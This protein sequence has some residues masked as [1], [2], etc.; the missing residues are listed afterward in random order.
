[1]SSP[2]L[3]KT[4]ERQLMS[5]LSRP[6]SLSLS[7]SLALSVWGLSFTLSANVISYAKSITCLE[8][9][10][11]AVIYVTGKDDFVEGNISV[12]LNYVGVSWLH[13][14]TL[15]SLHSSVTCLFL[16]TYIGRKLYVIVWKISFQALKWPWKHQ[17]YII[18]VVNMNHV[19]YP[20]AIW[21]KIKIKGIVYPPKRKICH[22]LHTLMLFQDH[23][24]G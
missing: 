9:V 10:L 15:T 5:I 8:D 4:L 3:V 21:S 23:K 20:E 16:L 17:T 18:K 11:Q 13:L 6:Y 19:S 24:T 12:H 2:R 1:M 7:C 14:L 22:Q